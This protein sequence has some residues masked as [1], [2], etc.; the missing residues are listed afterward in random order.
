M[1]KSK[2]LELVKNPDL[3]EEKDLTKL[4]E[5]TSEHPYSQIIH[6]LNVKGLKIWN[7]PD[8]ENA[9]NLTAVYSYDRNVLHSIVAEVSTGEQA[10]SQQTP[11]PADPGHPAEELEESIIE[12]TSDFE[13]INAD[14]VEKDQSASQQEDEE[15]PG[16]EQGKEQGKGKEEVGIESEKKPGLEDPLNLEIEASGIHAELMENLSQ[17]QKLREQ[18]K[19][20]NDETGD[21]TGHKEQIEIVDDFIKN[22]PVLSKPNLNAESEIMS[23]KDMAKDSGKFSDELASE[24]LAKILLKQGK[25]K[26]AE[27][28]YKKLIE[29]FPKKKTYF[30]DQIKKI[31]KK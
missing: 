19:G 1:N 25:R 22:S 31:K 24:N 26:D 20:Q 14:L 13:W 12:E 7:K 10:T 28:I 4:A 8:F 11:A 21:Q 5:L 18:Y 9:L 3:I 30:A 27:K 29:K 15:E 23:Q 17:L 6:V 16:Q 2:F